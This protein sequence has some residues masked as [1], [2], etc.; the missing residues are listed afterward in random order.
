MRLGV[1]IGHMNTAQGAMLCKPYDFVSEYEYHT[2]TAAN[3]IAIGEHEGVEVVVALRDGVGISG[4]YKALNAAHVD[5]AIE[6]HFN[7]FNAVAE[8]TETLYGDTPTFGKSHT[9]ERLALTVQN[10]M[11]SLYGRQGLQNRGAK[12]I[13]LT[14][15]GGS[16]VNQPVSFP[17]VLIEPFFGDK[18]DEARRAIALQR[19]L[20]QTLIRAFK[21]Y[22]KET[23]I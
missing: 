13:K 20:A 16:N 3:M 12:F 22:M 1:V 23:Q 15:R 19:D 21:A 5:A 6:L 18:I 14:D 10:H 4:A 11:V 9:A 2:M 17:C 8:G 7:S